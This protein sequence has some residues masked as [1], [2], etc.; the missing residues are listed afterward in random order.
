[1]KHFKL[2]RIATVVAS[3]AL[4]TSCFVGGAYAKF[5][6][7]T[8][9]HDN[10]RTAK[11]GIEVTTSQNLF[12]P[13]Y[14]S[15]DTQFSYSGK[16]VLSANGND[17]VAPGT[18]GT[19]NLLTLS[20]APEVAV[21]VKATLNKDNALA[22]ITLPAKTGY[23]DYTHHNAA[24]VYDRKFDV[25]TMYH[26]IQWSLKHDGKEVARGNLQEIEKYLTGSNFSGNYQ[27]NDPKLAALLGNWTL[28]WAWNYAGK[29]AEDT[30]IGN[31]AA[32]K[33]TD[34]NVLLNEAFNFEIVVTQID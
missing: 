30:Y 21:N 17:V 33:A 15:E 9:T 8:D 32:G 25:K 12:S 14:Q 11:F 34:N 29:E 6:T 13:S 28:S 10:A 5:I 26:P 2:N 31:V 20:G 27:P 4:I 7:G 3:L 24:G 18:K 19:F 23:T 16:S 1:M 22:M